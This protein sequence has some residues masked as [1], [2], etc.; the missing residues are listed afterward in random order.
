M[1]THTNNTE[2]F[3]QKIGTGSIVILL[4]GWGCDWQI[5]SSLIPELSNSFQLILPDLPGFGNSKTEHIDQWNTPKYVEWLEAFITEVAPNQNF[6]LIGHSL[7]G[8]IT[9][10]LAATS[11]LAKKINKLVI[12]DASGIPTELTPTKQ[13]QKTILGLIPRSLKNLVP[14]ELKAELLT[15]TNSST[16]NFYADSDHKKLLQTLIAE[17]IRPHLKHITAPTY[18]LWGNTDSDTPIQNGQEFNQLI[19]NSQLITFDAGHFP[20][21]ERQQLFL[22]EL[23]KLL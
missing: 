19:P 16:D 7:G 9:S 3:Y 12:V 1:R 23:T 5:W 18:I 13:F 15:K 11:P 10:V 22:K 14:T 6:T 21:I 8:K 20:F 17:D 2:T 4:H